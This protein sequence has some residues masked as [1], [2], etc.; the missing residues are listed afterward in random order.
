MSLSGRRL[1]ALGLAACLVAVAAV[2]LW[3]THPQVGG[4]YS[5]IDRALAP[6]VGDGLP[7]V[8][9]HTGVLEFGG[10]VVMFLPL[11]FL[12]TLALR[13]SLWWVAPLACLVLSCGIELT[14]LLILTGRTFSVR[15]IVGNT[16]G[17]VIGTAIAIGARGIARSVARRRSVT[18]G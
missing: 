4:L 7:P 9:L 2:V 8:L 11:G 5:E 13:R 17:G 15:D 6:L 3:P 12:G 18:A 1:A 10:N 16:I 14:Q